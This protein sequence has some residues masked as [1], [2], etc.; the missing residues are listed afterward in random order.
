VELIEAITSRKSI[1]AYKSTPVPKAILAELLESCIRAPSWANTQPWEFA[2]VGGKVMDELKR[3]LVQKAEADTPANPDIPAP[4]FA[5]RYLERRRENGRRLFDALG[6][7]REDSE[8][9]HQWYLTGSRFFD[10]PNAIIVYID[11]ALGAWSILD[12]G[13]IMQTIMLAAQSY[14]LGTCALY[15]AVI[16]PEELRRVLNIPESKLIVCGLAIGYPDTD[17]PQNKFWTT[18]DPLESFVT[19]HG[20]DGD[21]T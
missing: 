7:A 15:R 16:Y 2:V 10:A 20:F 4:T 21:N 18:R 13:I 17:A 12:V 11:K 14:G 8:K 9:R 1:R 6:I 3:A 5:D 19:W